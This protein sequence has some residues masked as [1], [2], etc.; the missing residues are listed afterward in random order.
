VL[1][2][3]G[4]TRYFH[5]VSYLDAAQANLRRPA[6][7]R[8]SRCVLYSDHPSTLFDGS[9]ASGGVVPMMLGVLPRMGLWRA[10]SRGRR[11]TLPGTYELTAAGI[12]GLLGA[13]AR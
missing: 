10:R 7:G 12:R 1:G 9:A 11:S 13:S 8:V 5:S 6:Q 2:R 4:Q 3:S